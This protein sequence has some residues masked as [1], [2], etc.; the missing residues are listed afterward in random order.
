M[1]VNGVISE[2]Y[3]QSL[4]L[5]TLSSRVDSIMEMAEQFGQS[6]QLDTILSRLETIMEYGIGYHDAAEHIGSAVYADQVALE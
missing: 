2:Q 3:E 5:D 4:R 6:T 1:V